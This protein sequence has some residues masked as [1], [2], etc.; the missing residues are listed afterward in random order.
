[1]NVHLI[2]RYR[3][4]FKSFPQYSQFELTKLTVEKMARPCIY[5]AITTMIAFLSLITADIKPVIDFGLMMTLGLIVVYI[6]T[7][8]LFPAF[9]MLTKKTSAKSTSGLASF[10]QLTAVLGKTTENKP[11]LI[12]ISSLLLLIFGITGINRLQVENSF[13]SY[14]DKNTD[15]FL[16]YGMEP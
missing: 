11:K 10:V 7:F 14:F 3:E 6:T 2:V 5:T 16:N 4:L 13:V 9:L 15:I 8:L 12:W 1:M